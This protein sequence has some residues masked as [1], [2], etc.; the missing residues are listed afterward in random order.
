[1]H[2]IATCRDGKLCSDASK[3]GR[4]IVS[5]ITLPIDKVTT[6]VHD[7]VQVKYFIE[8]LKELSDS[9]QKMSRRELVCKILERDPSFAVT[10]IQRAVNCLLESKI[11]RSRF[12]KLAI[13]KRY[14]REVKTIISPSSNRELTIGYLEDLYTREWNISQSTPTKWVEFFLGVVS[15]LQV[16]PFVGELAGASGTSLF[17][18]IVVLVIVCWLFVFNGTYFN[19]HPILIPLDVQQK[20]LFEY[21]A[22]EYAAHSTP[23]TSRG[24]ELAQRAKLK[25]GDVVLDIGCGDGRTTLALFKTNEKVESIYGNDISESQIEKANELAGVPE[26]RPFRSIASFECCDFMDYEATDS[27]GYSLAFSNSAIHWIGP[28]AYRHIFD[29]LVPGGRLCV[30]QAAKDEYQDL[31]DACRSLISEMGLDQ[32]FGDWDVHDNDYYTPSAEVMRGLLSSIGYSNIEVELDVI[33]YEGKARLDLYEAFIVASLHPY[34]RIIKNESTC[35]QFKNNL[36]KKLI[37]ERTPAISRRLVI[38]A[39]KPE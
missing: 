1:M 28:E 6:M 29:L 21:D 12:S 2:R 15:V 37:R 8:I 10:D 27:Q 25:D 34:F 5:T 17:V 11:I 23:Q 33:N 16:V 36:R 30:D 31:H 18:V 24:I 26:N 22:N 7:I 35:E 39:S 3:M 13:S 9:G 38:L 20:L 14:V 19:K 32:L 4:V